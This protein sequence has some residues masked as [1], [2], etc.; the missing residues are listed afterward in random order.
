MSADEILIPV[1]VLEEVFFVS[2][3]YIMDPNLKTL[4]Q[5]L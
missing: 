5:E 1:K 4:P 2:F 3:Y